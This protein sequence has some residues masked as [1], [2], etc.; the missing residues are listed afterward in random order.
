LGNAF[1]VAMDCL[2]D[3]WQFFSE[4]VPRR[5]MSAKQLRSA[6]GALRR[7][8]LVTSRRNQIYGLAEYAT[9]AEGEAWRLGGDVEDH[10]TTPGEEPN[11]DQAAHKRD[12]LAREHA[13]AEEDARRDAQP[14]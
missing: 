14:R 5:P 3:D 10:V 13:L 4:L 2:R 8:G 7:G 9:T 6:L 12:R 1:S 11:I